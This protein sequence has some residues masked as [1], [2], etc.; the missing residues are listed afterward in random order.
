MGINISKGHYGEH[1]CETILN[2][3]QIFMKICNL[4]IF[5]VLVL[6]AILFS[7][8]KMNDDRRPITKAHFENFVLR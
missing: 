3:G 4:K 6:A 8:Q 5:L 1:L 2:L 7:L